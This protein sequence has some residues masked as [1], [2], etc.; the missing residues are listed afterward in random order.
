[1]VLALPLPGGVLTMPWPQPLR[2]RVKDIERARSFLI[3]SK[4]SMLGRCVRLIFR[5]GC[6]RLCEAKL[7]GV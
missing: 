2:M 6:R 7:K 5:P 4:A 3:I 1:V